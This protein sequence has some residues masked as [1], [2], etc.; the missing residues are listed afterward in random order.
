M[1]VFLL[2]LINCIL[3]LPFYT[4]WSICLIFGYTVWVYGEDFVHLLFETTRLSGFYHFKPSEGRRDH[5]PFWP[6][7]KDIDFPSHWCLNTIRLGNSLGIRFTKSI[8]SSKPSQSWWWLSSIFTWYLRF[9]IRTKPPCLDQLQY[10]WLCGL[11][12]C[13]KLLS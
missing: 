2:L 9:T 10:F 3:C 4:M 1:W 13:H 8:C 12:I 11:F 7:V 5:P 6:E